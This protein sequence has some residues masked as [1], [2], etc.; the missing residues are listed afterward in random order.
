MLRGL[1]LCSLH[2][3]STPGDHRAGT[4]S[5]FDAVASAF[6]AFNT[7]RAGGAGDGSEVVIWEEY[8]GDMRRLETLTQSVYSDA[9]DEYA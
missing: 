4:P 9:Q 3:T 6:A 2:S 5:G 7:V 1:S 8:G